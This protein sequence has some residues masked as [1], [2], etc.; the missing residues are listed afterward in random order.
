[1][2]A[3]ILMNFLAN[4][5]QLSIIQQYMINFDRFNN[6]ILRE[7][8]KNGRISNT[9]LANRVGLSASACLRRVQE[10]EKA[11]VITGYRAVIN[12]QAVGIGFSAYLAIGLTDH[13]MPS[14]QAFEQAMRDAPVVRECHNVTGGIEYLVLVEVSDITAYKSF[15]ADVL[16]AL[17]QV[18]S[19]T[20][21]V[22][23]DSPK[24]ERG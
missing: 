20:T 6:N 10:L 23:I 15:H 9:D 12:P 4:I 19:I 24:N 16:G 17:P 7:L 8:Q 22:I 3:R 14:Q 11:N 5:V 2:L 18:N 1:M 13:T 21:Y